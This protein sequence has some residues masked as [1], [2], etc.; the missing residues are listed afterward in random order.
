MRAGRIQ[1]SAC[2]TSSIPAHLICSAGDKI[3]PFKALRHGIGLALLEHLLVTAAG[4]GQKFHVSSQSKTQPIRS[5]QT[6]APG[7][8][9]A[10]PKLDIG[11]HQI[12]NGGGGHRH[13]PPA[14]LRRTHDRRGAVSKNRCCKRSRQ[15]RASAPSQI[16]QPRASLPH[17]LCWSPS[18]SLSPN[19]G[20]WCSHG[21][22][23]QRSPTHISPFT[24]ACGWV[25]TRHRFASN[26]QRRSAHSRIRSPRRQ[27]IDD[28]NWPGHNRQIRSS[29]HRGT[30]AKDSTA[31]SLHF[32]CILCIHSLCT[33]VLQACIHHRTGTHPRGTVNRQGRQRVMLHSER[34]R[35]SSQS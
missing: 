35:H 25:Q 30:L 28:Y 29:D 22:P 17:R 20:H 10:S 27:H 24:H 26:A 31:H 6:R 5:R 9:V 14:Q 15:G 4:F 21:G 2:E 23:S 19:T 33:R 12:H 18:H 11:P 7:Q 32:G 8:G 1:T 3:T 34:L 16:R 13:T